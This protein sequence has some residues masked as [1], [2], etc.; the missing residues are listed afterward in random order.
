MRLPQ[1]EVLGPDASPRIGLAVSG[2]GQHLRCQRAEQLYG[3]LMPIGFRAPWR[4]DRMR[5]CAGKRVEKAG[6]TGQ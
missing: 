1:D 4:P 3:K 6:K 2:L 5:P